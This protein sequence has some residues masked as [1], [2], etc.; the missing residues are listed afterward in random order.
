MLCLVV[1]TGVIL[2]FC[3]VLRVYD[4]CVDNS[5]SIKEEAAKTSYQVG[6]C[7]ILFCWKGGDQ[8][9]PTRHICD[10][11]LRIR[12][13]WPNQHQYVHHQDL[14]GRHDVVSSWKWFRHVL[15]EGA[16]PEST[17]MPYLFR[18]LFRMFCSRS[19]VPTNVRMGN[20]VKN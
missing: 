10:V 11:L 12:K 19:H 6:I 15:C 1:I 18:I 4:W 13:S 2:I 9:V 16:R 14:V 7:F 8:R 20:I 17:Y 3:G 5:N